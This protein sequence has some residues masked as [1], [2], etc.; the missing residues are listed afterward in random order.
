MRKWTGGGSPPHKRLAD[1]KPAVDDG[2]GSILGRIPTEFKGNISVQS[3]EQTK[4]IE[5]IARSWR[6]TKSQQRVFGAIVAS[7][8]AMLSKAELARRSQCCEKT[9][10]R[11]ISKLAGTGVIE[12]R[13]CYA[14]NGGQMANKYA[15]APS[16][17]E[18]LNTSFELDFSSNPP[19]YAQGNAP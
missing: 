7:G 15:V 14:D 18:E 16:F 4:L 5:Y 10:D 12:V 1:E 8:G 9:V 17:V 11:A 13:A 6:L 3:D 2:R 19:R